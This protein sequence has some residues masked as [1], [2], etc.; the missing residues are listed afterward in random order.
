MASVLAQLD[1]GVLFALVSLA[2]S[3]LL[4]LAG[5]ARGLAVRARS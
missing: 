3:L 4:A 2:A 5:M 1:A